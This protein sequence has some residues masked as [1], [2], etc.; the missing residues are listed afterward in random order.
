MILEPDINRRDHDGHRKRLLERYLECDGEGFC[1]HE[2][3]ELLL[4]YAIPRKNTNEIAHRLVERFG[5]IEKI[6]EADIDDLKTVD[7]I[8]D[9]SAA[10]VHLVLSLAQRYTLD[11]KIKNPRLNTLQKLI[12][13][14]RGSFVGATGEKVYLYFLDN[15]LRLLDARLV[16][17]GA[18]DEVKPLVRN[19]LELAILKRVNAIAIVHNHT[20]A[21]VEESIA[22]VEFTA[23][24]QRELDFIG[25]R[26][27]E[28]I[29]ID[30]TDSN[31]LL[32]KYGK[33]LPDDDRLVDM[34]KF[35][36]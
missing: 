24:L 25:I 32:L 13:Y 4:F 28:H 16:A 15:S 9:N 8:G 7:G 22:D 29:I 18:I 31:P 36:K 14:A 27:V 12:N 30:K 17:V 5:T 10:L 26:L 2:L 33:V 23:L 19:I 34:S 20:S 6:V 21:G 35:Y 11:G 3:I 1:D